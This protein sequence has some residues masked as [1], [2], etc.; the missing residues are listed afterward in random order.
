M[1]EGQ[2]RGAGSANGNKSKPPRNCEGLLLLRPRQSRGF[3][4]GR[5][6]ADKSGQASR[7]VAYVAEAVNVDVHHVGDRDQQLGMGIAIKVQVTA[8]L[9]RTAG[10][11]RQDEGHVAVVMGVTVAQLGAQEDH[12]V[13]Q[14]AITVSVSSA[15]KV[16]HEIAELTH[17]VLLVLHELVG[18]LAVA[19]PEVGRVVV[20][21]IDSLDP[22]RTDRV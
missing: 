8:G 3:F 11:A 15:R 4:Y 20:A 17:V 2:A 14:Q 22:Q 21:L 18:N 19:L 10:I 9:K 7:A 12:R 13:V 16:F 1:N 5:W 6:L